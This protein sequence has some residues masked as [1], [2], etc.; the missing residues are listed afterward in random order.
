WEPVVFE[1]RP[2]REIL[3][4]EVQQPGQLRFH[5]RNNGSKPLDEDVT[6]RT[7]GQTSRT[8]L[9]APAHGESGEIALPV[10]NL[11]PGA[12]W[13]AMDFHDGVSVQNFVTNWKCEARAEAAKLETIDLQSRFNDRVGQI[14]RNRYLAPRSPFC[15]L[16][17]PTQG[18][19]G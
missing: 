15:S 13:M 2:G 8:R 4:A 11:L 10:A 16:A 17:M 19:G 9:R 18:I 5:V 3:G 7:E 14:F 1:L 12:N 6:I